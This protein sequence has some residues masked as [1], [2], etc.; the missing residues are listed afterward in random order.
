ME[1]CFPKWMFVIWGFMQ[2]S[3]LVV[4]CINECRDVMNKFAGKVNIPGG[5]IE[6]MEGYLSLQHDIDQLES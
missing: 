3:L 5:A 6:S 4:I 1:G 2:R